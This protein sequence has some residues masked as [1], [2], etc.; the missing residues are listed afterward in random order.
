M[1]KKTLADVYGI[2]GDYYTVCSRT[3]EKIWKAKLRGKLRLENELKE[4]KE[5][6]YLAKKTERTEN[7]LA[8]GDEVEI[9]LTNEKE[10]QEVEAYIHALRERKNMI[11][12]ASYGKMQIL[13]AN[14]D[15]IALISSVDE[16]PFSYGF[17]DRVLVEAY[18]TDV[19]P[20]IVLNK[21]DLLEQDERISPRR[22]QE[23]R[24][25]ALESI[26]HY[27][28]IGIQ[29]FKEEFKY[30][31]SSKLWKALN[32]KR[33]ILIGQS[34]V[35]KSTLINQHSGE[36]KQL[37]ADLGVHKK[38][39]HT[40][41]NPK[42]YKT[43]EQG[44]LIDV[45]GIKEFGLQHRNIKEISSAFKEFGSSPCRFEDCS[46]LH[47]PGCHF[48][49]SLGQNNTLIPEWRYRSYASII[50]SLKEPHKIRKGNL[51]KLARN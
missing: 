41:T 12:R 15:S 9:V 35:G 20:I 26:K 23:K 10:R 1:D 33:V 47:E 36:E 22:T 19:T 29:I 45:P 42:M 13:G 46:H 40:T 24:A 38:G 18:S 8:V 27:Q 37:T 6:S 2:Y 50:H 4:K 7:A 34:G 39:K 14:V 3:D 51:K 49:E 25:W 31:V 30:R 21:C 5:K 32:K 11:C 44:G 16:P 17:I 28:S 48:R 43:D